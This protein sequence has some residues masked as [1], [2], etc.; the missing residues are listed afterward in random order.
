MSLCNVKLCVAAGNNPAE[1]SSKT[2]NI[3]RGKKMQS[4]FSKCTLIAL[5]YAWIRQVM[6]G[7]NLYNS[8]YMTPLP[9]KWVKVEKVAFLVERN[10]TT[11]IWV[12]EGG[13]CLILISSWID[14][15]R[16]SSAVSHCLWGW[17]V[18]KYHLGWWSFVANVKVVLSAESMH[19]AELAQVSTSTACVFVQFYRLASGPPHHTHSHLSPS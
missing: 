15:F 7:L 16:T 1:V 11:R 4:E 14:V 12:G 9:R 10:L 3:L 5:V 18:D 19:T 17:A 6:D 13:C 2:N 8:S